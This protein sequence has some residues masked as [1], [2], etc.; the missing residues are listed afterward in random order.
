MVNE[1][2]TY[3]T[4]ST[5]SESSLYSTSQLTRKG[6]KTTIDTTNER[7]SKVIEK[8]LSLKL[9][10]QPLPPIRIDK[11]LFEF[12]YAENLEIQH[13]SKIDSL[14]YKITQLQR[15]IAEKESQY[16][17]I[18]TNL[19]FESRRHEKLM[20]AYRRMEYTRII[21]KLVVTQV[22]TEY[23][24]KLV[25]DLHTLRAEFEDLI[26]KRKTSFVLTNVEFD[27]T[28]F[29]AS[30]YK[31]EEMKAKYDKEIH[32]L[33][34]TISN[35]KAQISNKRNEVLQL[36][37]VDIETREA[38]IIANGKIEVIRREL[39]EEIKKYVALMDLKLYFDSELSIYQKLI[40]SEELRLIIRKVVDKH[41]GR[42]FTTK[43]H[44]DIETVFDEINMHGDYIQLTNKGA[45]K[46]H[47]GN[48][49][50]IAEDRSIAHGKKCQYKFEPDLDLLPGQSVKI[51][52]PNAG[53]THSPPNSYVMHGDSWPSGDKISVQLLDNHNKKIAHLTAF[54]EEDSE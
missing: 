23:D 37:T 11:S 17:E 29:V 53:G 34:D 8:V 41:T 18:Q 28:H 44:S 7:L 43:A 45:I 40:A 3:S 48:W 38:E 52:S 16:N 19:D 39:T 6:E 51:Y 42:S 49:T 5:M 35:L 30:V 46:N 22:A 27:I 9:D 20:A 26:Q 2:T 12:G 21:E 50:I 25:E 1:Q 36:K 47:L 13:R 31:F 32:A 4:Y 10:D 24:R 33:E 54:Y 15:G 14:F